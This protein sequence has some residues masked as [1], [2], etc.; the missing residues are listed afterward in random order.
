VEDVA[1]PLAGEAD[2]PFR[3]DQ[4]V[5]DL[6]QPAPRRGMSDDVLMGIDVSIATP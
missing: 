4:C 1:E 5:H 3:A 2:G 6:L